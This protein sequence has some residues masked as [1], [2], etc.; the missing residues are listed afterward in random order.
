MKGRARMRRELLV[1]LAVPAWASCLGYSPFAEYRYEATI[2]RTSYGVAHISA[3]DLG[4]AGFGQ[5]YAFAQ[6]H[7]CVL[8][9]QI[10]KV[11]SERAMFLGPDQWEPGDGVHLNSDFAYKQLGITKR[12]EAAWEQQ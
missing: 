8:A 5:G 6:D 7:A 9:D 12:A 2:R 10:V 3:D 1:V 4:S 11:R